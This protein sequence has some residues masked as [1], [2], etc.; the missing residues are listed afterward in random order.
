MPQGGIGNHEILFAIAHGDRLRATP[1]LM[2][3]PQ[4]I[5]R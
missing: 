4:D 5:A 2:R 1:F 3:R